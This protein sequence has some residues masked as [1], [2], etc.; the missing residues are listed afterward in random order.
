MY[1]MEKFFLQYWHAFLATFQAADRVFAKLF[2]LPQYAI[3]LAR[4]KF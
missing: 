3:F 2:Y 4:I 1:L